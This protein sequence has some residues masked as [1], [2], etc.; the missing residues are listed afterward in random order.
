MVSPVAVPEVLG[1]VEGG[2]DLLG[3]FGL[4]GGGVIARQPRKRMRIVFLAPALAGVAAGLLGLAAAAWQAAMLRWTGSVLH[5]L[6]A[7]AHHALLQEENVHETPRRRRRAVAIAAAGPL[8]GAVLAVALFALVGLK[9]ALIASVFIGVLASA[10]MWRAFA[11][12]PA[13]PA[14]AGE[15][16]LSSRRRLRNPMGSLLLSVVAFEFGNVAATLLILRV[17]LLFKPRVGAVAAIEIG[18]A[19]YAAYV[20]AGRLMEV[21][22]HRMHGARAPVPVLALGVTLFLASY[23]GFAFTDANLAVVTVCFVAAGLATSAVNT[24]EIALVEGADR[25][26]TIATEGTLIAIRSVANFTAS[27]VTGVLWSVVSVRA[28]LLYLGGWLLISLAGLVVA[29][30]RHRRLIRAMGVP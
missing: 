10:L 9:G 22:T 11:R 8:S 19:L 14:Q 29:A 4:I 13:A 3:G 15:R 7:P 6:H 1:L 30:R 25:G 23:L 20:A 12:I 17:I 21:L 18:V 27:V 16:L 26:M 5:E 28:A 24:T 2:N